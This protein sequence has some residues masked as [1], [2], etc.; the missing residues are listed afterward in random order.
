M[1]ESRPAAGEAPRQ[2]T[3]DEA[4][5]IVEDGQTVGVVGAGGGLLE[6]DAL[7]AAL[8]RRFA[9]TGSPRDLTLVHAFGLGDRRNRGFTPVARR[10]LLKRVIGGHWG[11]T[12][13]LAGLAARGDI[14]A[15]NIS[16]GV[17]ALL[18]RE[19]AGGRPGLVT[20]IGLGTFVDP[21]LEGGRLNRRTTE[22]LVELVE[23]DGR[24]YLRYRA[25]PVH[26]ALIRGMQADTDGYL[27]LTGECAYL[28]T[29][30]LAAAARR[31]GGTVIAQVK[32]VV[33][34]GTLAP[35]DIH[36]PGALVDYLVEHPEQWQTY[37]S[38]FNSG[39]AG[40]SRAEP[41]AA[42][43]VQ[44]AGPRATIARRAALYL[45]PGM[46]VNIGV[47]VPDGVGA[48]LRQEGCDDQVTLTLE[49]GIVGG[50]S[51]QGVIFGAASNQRAFLGTP[52]MM[53]LYH[54]GGLDIAFLGFAE[55]DARGNVNV[56]RFGGTIMGSGGFVDIAQSART[57]VFCGTLIAGGVKK[58]VPAVEQI[59]F[60]GRE[61][62]RRGHRVVV[63]TE[64]AVFELRSDGLTL[65]EIAPGSRVEDIRAAMAFEPRVS[66]EVTVT[67]P[68]VFEAG[69]LGLA[70]CW[71][72]AG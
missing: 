59:T 56:S 60:H 26:V 57:V 19:I 66:G 41:T 28:D 64:R 40:L 29:L 71:A 34:A 3:A 61:A 15:Y 36:V 53:D 63:V 6:P 44:E 65:V 50:V 13:A 67:D 4:L 38:E 31:C 58:L 52:E 54:G 2:V 69:S 33:P 47:G 12:P 21:R 22:D 37:E 49:H 11:Q 1:A 43:K 16:S 55:A 68:A 62:L 20:E 72:R 70:E 27:S 39:Y 10:G 45:R 35:A 7:I 24:E 23:V 8:G 48:L 42:S 18:H 46:V 17:L 51:A 14:E 30:A 25:Y 9:A 32:R 5:A